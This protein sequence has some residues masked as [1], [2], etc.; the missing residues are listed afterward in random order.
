MS[1]AIQFMQS[2]VVVY[3]LDHQVP[4][5]RLFCAFPLHIEERLECKMGGLGSFWLNGVVRM[6]GMNGTDVFLAV[7]NGTDGFSGSASFQ[8]C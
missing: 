3:P 2:I 6:N 7:L 8:R 5:G 1:A 4:G